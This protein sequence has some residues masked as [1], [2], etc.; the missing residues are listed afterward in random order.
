MK[1]KAINNEFYNDLGDRWYFAKDDPV[2]LLRAENKVK[3]AWISPKLMVGSK[4][5]DVGCGAG[6]MANQ[7]AQDG[8]DV[9][10]LDASNESLNVARRFDSTKKVKYILGNAY[11]LPFDDQKFDSVVCLD[12]LEHVEDPALVIKE[13]SRVL[14]PGGD[15]FFH[16]FDR[17]WLSYLIVIKGVEWFVKN[18]PKNMH[19]YPL[20]IKPQ[21]LQ[22]MMDKEQ[23]IAK[24][25]V[26]IRP[27]VFNRAFFSSLFNRIVSDNFE[28][29]TT[30]SLKISYLG[31]AVKAQRA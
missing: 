14:K 4:I 25:W 16:T 8:F 11:T 12:F 22:G 3:Y 6:F 7:L 17:N 19:V 1:S 18:T 26:G 27:K 2:A 15:F 23:L 20:F 9:V 24:E 28:F 31:H 13:I 29:T 21:E 30:K 5:L 10:A